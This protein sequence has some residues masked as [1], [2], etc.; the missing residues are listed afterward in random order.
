MGPLARNGLKPYYH[1]I[2][3]IDKKFNENQLVVSK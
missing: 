3:P 1:H 2:D